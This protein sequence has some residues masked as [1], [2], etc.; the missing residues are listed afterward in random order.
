LSAQYPEIVEQ[1]AR[2]LQE[3]YTRDVPVLDDHDSEGCDAVSLSG[4]WGLW[5]DI[6]L[7][8][9][10]TELDKKSMS[11]GAADRA[12]SLLFTTLFVDEPLSNA[13]NGCFE[14]CNSY[15]G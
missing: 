1:M 3:H 2:R 7:L 8:N 13:T 5:N 9:E 6:E 4:E 11:Y 10:Y 15:N 14:K 12:G